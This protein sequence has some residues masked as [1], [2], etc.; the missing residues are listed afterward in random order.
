[1]EKIV[2]TGGLGYLGSE[3]CHLYSGEIKKN[4]RDL[5]ESGVEFI[6]IKDLQ[7]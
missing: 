1:M 7:K 5:I 6:S 4:N 2:I 3:L